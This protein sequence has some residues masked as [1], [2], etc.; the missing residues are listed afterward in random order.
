M[1][2]RSSPTARPVA[3]RPGRPET[4]EPTRGWPR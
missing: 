2:T 1:C 3:D 4:A